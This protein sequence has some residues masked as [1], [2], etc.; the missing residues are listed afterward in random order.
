MKKIGLAGLLLG[1]S[2]VANAGEGIFGWIY[3]TDLAPKGKFEY[4]H[5]SFLQNGQSQGAYQYLKNR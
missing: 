1:L 3:T 4:E 2:V 5:I